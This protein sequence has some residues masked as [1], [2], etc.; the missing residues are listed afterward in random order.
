MPRLLA[1][2]PPAK[3]A[4]EKQSAVRS[5]PSKKAATAAVPVSSVQTG[6]VR[7]KLN[8]V[9]LFAYHKAVPAAFGPRP[10]L[11]VTRNAVLVEPR[12]RRMVDV[13][14]P[15]LRPQKVALA[16]V[17]AA[18]AVSHVAQAWLLALGAQATK[19]PDSAAARPTAIGLLPTTSPRL[20]RRLATAAPRPRAAPTL[21][22]TR[23]SRRAV[24]W[25]LLLLVGAAPVVVPDTALRAA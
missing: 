4:A 25:P 7:P 9:V 21:C 19:G 17:E 12:P 13:Q 8:V 18:V 3:I 5:R 23:P 20:A 16:V 2:R 11:A 14:S 24:A 22:P 10:R 15:C 1:E 6:P